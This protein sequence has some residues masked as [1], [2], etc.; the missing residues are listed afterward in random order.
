MNE[1]K[2]S[3]DITLNIKVDSNLPE[4][5]LMEVLNKTEVIQS[6]NRKLKEAMQN[7]GLTV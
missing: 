6:L 3:S 1:T 2:N 7:N 4:T 5:K